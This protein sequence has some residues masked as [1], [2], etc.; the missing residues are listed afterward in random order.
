MQLC[1]QW[2]CQVSGDHAV[3][4]Q[5]SGELGVLA[6]RGYVSIGSCYWDKNYK[7]SASCYDLSAM[8]CGYWDSANYIIWSHS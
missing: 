6:Q 7:I 1:L 8:I 4:C 5:V 3:I 2:I